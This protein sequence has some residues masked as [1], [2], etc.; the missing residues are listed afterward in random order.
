[1]YEPEY[2]WN[3]WVWYSRDTTPYHKNIHW[4]IKNLVI[5]KMIWQREVSIWRYVCRALHRATP[6]LWNTS[7]TSSNML[8][9]SSQQQQ[10]R[11]G[12]GVWRRA[13]KERFG[14]TRRQERV[15]RDTPELLP[16]LSKAALSAL[17][18]CQHAFAD[19]RWNCSSL[20]DAPHLS[21]DLTQGKKF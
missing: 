15:C 2:G 5:R 18:A 19:R 4:S 17:A 1:M 10:E 14:L 20:A 21:P 3:I 12:G 7:M 6:G 11:S 13:L 8:S 9:P 16:L